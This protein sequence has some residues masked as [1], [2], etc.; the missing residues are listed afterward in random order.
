PN[1]HARANTIVAQNTRADNYPPPTALPG[2]PV[3]NLRGLP[4][5]YRPEVPA[6]RGNIDELVHPATTQNPAL[7]AQE[8]KVSA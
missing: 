5:D 4:A 3:V 1:H 7:K 2:Q 8:L 6:N